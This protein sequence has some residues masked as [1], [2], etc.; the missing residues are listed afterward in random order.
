MSNIRVIGVLW[1]VKPWFELRLPFETEPPWYKPVLRRRWRKR[2]ERIFF[3][4]QDVGLISNIIGDYSLP[5][6]G[7][8]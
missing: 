2:H 7:S 5:W 8:W 4:E 1:E 6:W 3:L